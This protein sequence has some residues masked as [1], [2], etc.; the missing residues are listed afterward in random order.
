MEIRNQTLMAEC[1]VNKLGLTHTP[2]FSNVGA[3]FLPLGMSQMS[4]DEHNL[5]V[6]PRSFMV[7]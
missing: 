5:E 1:G 6:T 3:K 2:S 4:V 7:P